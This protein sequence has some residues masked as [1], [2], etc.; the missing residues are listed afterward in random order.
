[1]SILY[2]AQSW[3]FTMWAKLKSFNR[4]VRPVQS[5]DMTTAFA[6][7]SFMSPIITECIIFTIS[8]TEGLN[9][10]RGWFRKLFIFILGITVV[11]IFFPVFLSPFFLTFCYLSFVSNILCLSPNYTTISGLNSPFPLFC[12]PFFGSCRIWSTLSV[13]R[14]WHVFLQ[15]M[16][17]DHPSF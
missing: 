7:N 2:T 1:M 16:I 10:G 5:Y 13:H 11:F 14:Y 15:P 9:V 6:L 3:V 4:Q 8:K 12:L 17:P